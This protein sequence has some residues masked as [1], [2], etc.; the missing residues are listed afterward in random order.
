MAKE[1]IVFTA[2]VDNAESGKSLK[3]LKQEFNELQKELDGCVVGTKKYNDALVKLG[4]VKDDMGDL[5]D[6]INALNPEGKVQAFTNVA[7]KLAGGFQAATGAAA[8]FGIQSEDL[9]KQL[10]KVQAAT[11]LAEGIRSVAGLADGFQVLSVVVKTNVV[12]AFATMK[13]ALISTGIG[14]LIVAVGILINETIKYNEAIDEEWDKQKKLNDELKKT[15][16]LYAAQAAKSEELRNSRK[17]GVYELER[18]LKLLEASGASASKIEA[19]KLEILDK[20]IFNLKVRRET[21]K[22]SAEDAAKFNKQILDK[23]AEKQSLIEGNELKKREAYKKTRD[24]QIQSQVDAYNRLADIENAKIDADE[25]RAKEEKEADAQRDLDAYNRKAEIENAQIDADEA[26]VK[27]N[28]EFMIGYYQREDKRLEESIAKAKEL[29]QQE[30]ATMRQ[31]EDNS[32]AATKALSD[33]FFNHRLN[34]AKGNAAEELKIRKNQFAVDKA[35]SISRAVIDGIRSVQAALTIPPPFGT[36]LA[37]VN[38]ALAAANVAKIASM[39]FN[40]GAASTGGSISSAAPSI[41]TPAPVNNGQPV[42]QLNSNA[43]QTSSEIRAYVV[44]SDI[45]DKQKNSNRVRR[46]SKF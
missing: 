1:D 19:K 23:E 45:S 41:S 46:Q 8:L 42:T 2:R 17:G 5:R 27:R 39:Q 11:A 33:A 22:D 9:E 44:E 34:Q 4:K 21:V 40:S 7:G 35:F 43:Q 26:R 29:K 10:L 25:Q 32:L 28:D 3:A 38:T 18:E 31:I 37:I 24:E 30:A 20:E 15:T 36:A 14:A 12:A 6:T 16:D 13:A